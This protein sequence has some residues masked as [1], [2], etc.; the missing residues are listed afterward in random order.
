[1]VMKR[2]LALVLSVSIIAS[3]T[4]CGGSADTS[5]GSSS[6]S[7]S[8]AET[9]SSESGDGID[10]SAW[11]ELEAVGNIKTEY[12]QHQLQSRLSL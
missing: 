9:V 2:F 1:M 6:A 12:L 8:S 5:A 7:Q 3:L 4:A 10:D 11:D